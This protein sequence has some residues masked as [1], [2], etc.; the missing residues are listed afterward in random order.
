MRLPSPQ[1]TTRT[2]LRYGVVA[3]LSGTVLLD[4]TLQFAGGGFSDLPGSTP[5]AT[6]AWVVTLL[7]F[8]V[9]GPTAVFGTPVALYLRFGLVSPAVVLIG[10]AGFWLVVAGHPRWVVLFV[11]LQGVPMTVLYGVTGTLEWYV[12]DRRG[13]LPPPARLRRAED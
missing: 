2:A 10:A 8:Y 12:R 9:F 11:L 13:T 1:T 7:V 4:A 5:V 6:L 3:G